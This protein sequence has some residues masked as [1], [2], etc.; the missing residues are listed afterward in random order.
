MR[1]LM[2]SPEIFERFEAFGWS[3]ESDWHVWV[4]LI[5][6]VAGFLAL[7]QNPPLIVLTVA[8]W[9]ASAVVVLERR[10]PRQNSA[11]SRKPGPR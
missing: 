5:F 1:P 11:R 10:G 3:L 4:A 9:F 6:L 7:A 8:F 2:A